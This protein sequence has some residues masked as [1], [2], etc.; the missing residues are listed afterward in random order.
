M[1]KVKGK[2]GLV[3]DPHTGSVI[4]VDDNAYRQAK[5]AKQRLLKERERNEELE[6]RVSKLETVLEQLLKEK[7]DG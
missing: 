7:Q 6:D 3:K 4:N 5:I 1:H 2:E